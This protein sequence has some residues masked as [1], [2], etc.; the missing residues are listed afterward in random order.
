[1]TERKTAEE[2]LLELEKKTEQLK[3][4][5]KTISAKVNKEGGVLSE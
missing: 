3:A 5:K 1:M 4:Q 2:K